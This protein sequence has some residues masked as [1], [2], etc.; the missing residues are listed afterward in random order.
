MTITWLCLF[1]LFF[2]YSF[3][4]WCIEVCAAAVQHRKFV[5]RGFVAGPLCPIYGFGAI[6]F[7][8]FLPELTEDPFF[9]F[10][11]GFV[12]A[13]LLEY[14][15]G[16]FFEKVYKKKLWDYSRFRYNVGGYICLPFSLLWGALSVVTVMFADPLLCGLFDRIPHLLSVVTSVGAGRAAPVGCRW[17]RF[18]YFKPTGTGKAPG[19]GL[20]GKA[21]RR[22]SDYRRAGPDFPFSGKCPDKTYTEATAEI[23]SFYQPGCSGKSQRRT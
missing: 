18:I 16:M 14:F 2:F 6:L 13:S 12:L 22:G 20:S 4:G 1:W 19:G 15:T 17:F 3:I 23:I 11:G 8:I 10:L 7:E 9:L 5:N 21:D